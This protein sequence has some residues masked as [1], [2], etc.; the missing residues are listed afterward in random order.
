MR[1][2]IQCPFEECK[3]V[4]FVPWESSNDLMKC[5]HCSNSVFCDRSAQIK[6]EDDA[7][8]PE[9]I[10]LP[11]PEGPTTKIELQ[12]VGNVGSLY[13]FAQCSVVWFQI[14]IDHQ[15]RSIK[16]KERGVPIRSYRRE[17]RVNLVWFDVPENVI[18]HYRRR[19]QVKPSIEERRYFWIRDGQFV[20]LGEETCGVLF[21]FPSRFLS[22]YKRYS[23]TVSSG[24]E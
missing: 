2:Y 21:D 17:K 13:I 14:T 1:Y 15:L 4:F 22:E 19:A 7:P 10:L 20:D 5:P 18:C 3:R 16:V 11:L 9:S 8:P 6:L 12:C 24:D 23:I